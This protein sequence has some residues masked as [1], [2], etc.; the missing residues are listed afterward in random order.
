MRS[1]IHNGM[2]LSLCVVNIVIYL[3]AIGMMNACNYKSRI[4]V[5]K[6]HNI[7]MR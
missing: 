1:Y 2:D 6:F 3:F 4:H 7:H 5:V